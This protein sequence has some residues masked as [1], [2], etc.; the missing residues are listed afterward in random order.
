MD[1]TIPSPS[2]VMARILIVDDDP[3]VLELVRDLLSMQDHSLDTG[4]DGAQ[5][6]AKAKT[7]AY[8]L[9]IIDRI[10]PVM[11]GIAAIAAIRANPAL[12]GLRILMFTSINSPEA[13]AQALQAGADGFLVKPIQLSEF[14]ATVRRALEGPRA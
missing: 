2:S 7:G 9:L 8:D 4:S 6:V 14:S 12:R 10:M 3:L 1:A 11:S 5:A 13:H